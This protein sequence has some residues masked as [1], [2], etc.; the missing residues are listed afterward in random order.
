MSVWDQVVGQPMVTVLQAAAEHSQTQEMTHAWLL[1]G[2]PGSGRSVLATAFAAALQCQQGQQQGQQGQ[3]QGQPK[4]CGR[5]PSCRQVLAGTH[6]DVRVVATEGLSITVGTVRELVVHAATVPVGG[7]WRILLIEDADRLTEDAA[8]ALLLSLEE[9]PRRTVWLLCCPST[10]DLPP[11]IRSRCRVV[12]LRTPPI[13]DVAALLEREGVAPARAQFAARAAQAHV[14]RA[15]ALATDDDAVA[16]RREVLVLPSRTDSIGDALAAAA[17]L[18][19]TAD[20]DAAAVCAPLEEAEVRDLTR[21]TQVDGAGRGR[22][23]GAAAAKREMETEHKRRRTR[24]TRDSLDRALVDLLGFYRDVLRVQAGAA[25]TLVN[26]D[27]RP[28]IERLAARTTPA[29]TARR[30]EVVSQTREALTAN[31]APLL[32]LESMTLRLARGA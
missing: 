19:A 15:R 26:D 8:D 6:P 14:G 29:W 16:R 7:G 25:D 24:V 28:T 12:A 20:A 31:A 17:A 18:L 32:T 4:G 9:P 10:E 2:P 27:M 22:I 3:Q 5:C 21:T 13:A 23:R 30:L 1:T 11:T